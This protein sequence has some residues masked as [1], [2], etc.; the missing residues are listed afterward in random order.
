VFIVAVC[1]YFFKTCLL[2]IDHVAQLDLTQPRLP[3]PVDGTS[4]L[5]FVQICMSL[6]PRADICDLRSHAVFWNELVEC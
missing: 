5:A 2:S 4:I 3:C 6:E 1:S